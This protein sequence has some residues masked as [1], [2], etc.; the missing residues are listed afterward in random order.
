[1]NERQLKMVAAAEEMMK[2]KGKEQSDEAKE[3]GYAISI[4]EYG[5]E[6]VLIDF[7]FRKRVFEAIMELSDVVNWKTTL[8]HVG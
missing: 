7:R 5:H 2:G 3:K 1:M 6:M 4:E 8:K